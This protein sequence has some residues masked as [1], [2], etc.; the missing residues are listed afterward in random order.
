MQRK[1]TPAKITLIVHTRLL[2]R[3][4]LWGWCRRLGAVYYGGS[5]SPEMPLGATA[6]PGSRAVYFAAVACSDAATVRLVRHAAAASIV[7]SLRPSTRA[8]SGRSSGGKL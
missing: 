3:R 4:D 1:P 2:W 5:N 6:N 8:S 7:I